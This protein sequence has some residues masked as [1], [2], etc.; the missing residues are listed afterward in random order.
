MKLE[1]GGTESIACP[2]DRLWDAL[3]DPTVLARCLPGCEEMRE[4][5]PNVY[6]VKMHLKVAAVSGS[7]EGVIK[8]SEAQPRQ[9]CALEMEGTGSLG[10]ATG[11][12]SF[13]IT[14]STPAS[15]NIAYQGEAELG[16]LIVGVGQRVLRSVSKHLLRQFFQTLKK[17]FA[18]PRGAD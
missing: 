15:S 16:R 4:S 13:D 5:A 6:A 12:A 7:I 8:L 9:H 14:A 3:Q 17:E 2:A 10:H 1:I 11:R 18:A